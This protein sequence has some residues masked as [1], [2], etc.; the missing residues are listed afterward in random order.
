MLRYHI[1]AAAVDSMN[2]N[3]A[4][5]HAAMVRGEVLGQEIGGVFREPAKLFQPRKRRPNRIPTA[6][7]EIDED[8]PKLKLRFQV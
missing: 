6:S 7:S 2:I 5:R 1:Q 8:V 3:N 4:T